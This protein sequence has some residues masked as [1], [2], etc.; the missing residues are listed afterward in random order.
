MIHPWRILR[1]RPHLS[2]AYAELPGDLLGTWAPGRVTLTRHLLQ[3]ERRC[4]LMHELVH[5]E[6]GL[7]HPA[8]AAKDEAAVDREA[9]RRLVRF[10]RL[11]AAVR[12][13]QDLDE[14]ADELWVT[15]DVLET[16]LRHL[17][18]SER[19]QLLEA[20]RDARAA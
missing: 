12:W 20:V 3:V 4:V 2:L 17:H 9:A 7:P 14:L 18:P 15:R 6:R 5:D 19:A 11:V 16:R 10:D 8:L 1:S 13:T